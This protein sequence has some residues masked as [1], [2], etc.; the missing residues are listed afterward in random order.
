[1]MENYLYKSLQNKSLL[2]VQKKYIPIY[3]IIAT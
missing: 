1:M 3:G 2:E